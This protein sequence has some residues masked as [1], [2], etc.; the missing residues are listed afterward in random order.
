LGAAQAVAGGRKSELDKTNE[1]RLRRLMELERGGSLG[2][3]SPTEQQAFGAERANAQQQAAAAEQQAQR[4]QAATGG[5]SG[6][7]LA[8]LR[9]EKSES[10]FDRLAEIAQAQR[11]RRVQKEA[12]QRAEISALQAADQ[13]G[14]F[15]RREAIF[16][17]L[18]QIAGGVGQAAATGLALSQQQKMLDQQRALA[19]SKVDAMAGVPIRDP[20]SLQSLLI[21]RGVPQDVAAQIGTIPSENITRHLANIKA[22]N[23]AGPEEELLMGLLLRRR[24]IEDVNTGLTSGT[25]LGVGGTLA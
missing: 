12:A 21:A 5:T 25:T 3:L 8:T 1:E 6:A 9:Q 7:D 17:G 22:G 15:R 4:L 20:Q 10:Q 2:N 19:Q 16:G 23:I 18:G 14:R 11:V 24:A 13:E